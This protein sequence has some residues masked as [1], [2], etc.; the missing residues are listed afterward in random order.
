MNGVL[1]SP[2]GFATA[3]GDTK[4]SRSC[5]STTDPN[6]DVSAVQQQV[7]K[8]AQAANPLAD[9]QSNQELIDQVS[10]QI[11]NVVFPLYALLA[12]I[13]LISI[14]GIINTLLLSVFERTRE[15]GLLRAV[16][17][18]RRQVRRMVRYES[19]ITSVIGATL[20]V[21]VGVVFGGLMI[22]RID[23]IPFAFPTAPDHHLLHRRDHRRHPG[24]DPAGAAR[25]AA[26]HPRRT[27]V[28]VRMSDCYR[29]GLAPA[30]GGRRI[31]AVR[32]VV[33]L[34][35]CCSG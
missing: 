34:V 18:T 16:G 13:V 7:K 30:R 3:L 22:Y 33:G 14:V 4:G 17:T 20:G 8:V 21:V 15:I 27:A 19:V 35:G 11:N 24:G 23:E 2:E 6:A 1:A 28:R 5:S 25:V 10:G 29:R 12:V 32:R 9:V 31:A 26:R